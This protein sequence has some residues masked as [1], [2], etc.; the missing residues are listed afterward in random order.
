MENK[1]GKIPQSM[2]KK[3]QDRLTVCD[4]A[5]A[6]EFRTL[7]EGSGNA[8]LNSHKRNNNVDFNI[9]YSIWDQTTAYTDNSSCTI[10]AANS[11]FLKDSNKEED[12]PVEESCSR[13]FGAAFHEL[14]HICYTC[15]SELKRM[16]ILFSQGLLEE[17][18]NMTKKQKNNY[19]SLKK[20]LVENKCIVE[21]LNPVAIKEFVFL[22]YK[23]LMNCIEDGRIEKL[24]LNNDT[25]FSGFYSGLVILRDY[26]KESIKTLDMTGKDI[27]TFMNLCLGYAKYGEVGNY[28][29]GFNAFEEAKP[30]IDEMLNCYKA[31]E[32]SELNMHL[33]LC[34]WP[35][36]E[37]IIQDAKEEAEQG[38][39]QGESSSANQQ[40]SDHGNGGMSSSCS[41]SAQNNGDSSDAQESEESSSSNNSESSEESSSKELKKTEE[42]LEK[43]LKE[44]LDEI[45]KN[46][47]EEESSLN[48]S[49]DKELK[50]ADSKAAQAN[51]GD[52]PNGKPFEGSIKSILKNLA[53]TKARE[54][55][56]KEQDN[57]ITD[58]IC[59]NRGFAVYHGTRIVSPNEHPNSNMIIKEVEQMSGSAVNKASKEIRRHLE[60]DMRTRENK[61][62]FSGKKFHAEKLVNRDF[63]YFGDTATKKDMPKVS[64]GLVVDESGSMCGNNRYVFARAAAITLYEIFEKIPNIDIAIYGHTT[65]NEV[66]IISYT[67]FGVKEKDVKKKLTSITGRAGNIDVVPITV[68]AENLLEQDAEQRM[69][70]IITDGLPYSFVQN[71]SPEQELSEVADKFAKKGID[72]IVASIGDDEKR[73]REIY[74]NQRFLDIKDP[75][76]LPN[77]LVNIIKR[78]L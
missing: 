49:L 57:K 62:K 55:I 43:S 22:I 28:P 54:K 60:Q 6:P 56:K 3:I 76:Q 11:M 1:I 65:H 13:I 12:I 44:I 20:L 35:E 50:E 77:K 59:A 37:Q 32:F 9:Y 46:I 73:I 19:D 51:E 63:R 39:A 34:I 26:H 67:D 7:L 72:I 58:K 68:M 64:I 61:R 17:P 30:I 16:C 27:P 75:S 18:V 52:V 40:C 23:N 25:R 48:D 71:K 74:K 78:K 5:T 69:M 4:I 38:N 21:G 36:I 15:F 47:P 2:I 45:E 29:G 8:M 10:N 14:G 33:L 42:I 31:K 41:Q 24:L 53:D 66:E 70:F